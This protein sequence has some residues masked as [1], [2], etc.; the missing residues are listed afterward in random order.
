MFGVVL[1]WVT[2]FV[3]EKVFGHLFSLFIFLHSFFALTL[4]LLFYEIVIVFLYINR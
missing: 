4:E 2:L 3:P 1:I